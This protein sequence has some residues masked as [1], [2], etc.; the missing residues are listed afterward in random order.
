LILGSLSNGKLVISDLLGTVKRQIGE[1]EYATEG[2][3]S[4]YE[5]KSQN[6]PQKE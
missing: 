4:Q 5:M 1:S 6:M 3:I 2:M